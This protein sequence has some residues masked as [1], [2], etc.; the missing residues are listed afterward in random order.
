MK[1]ITAGALR[2]LWHAARAV[3]LCAPAFYQPGLAQVAPSILQIDI[4]DHVLYFEDV[5]DPA[6]F[7][8]D[9]NIPARV[10]TLGFTRTSSIADIVAVNGQRA[11]GNFSTVYCGLFLRTAPTPGLAIADII[12]NAVGVVTFEILKSDGTSI[13]TIVGTGLAGGTS[14][15]GA[16]LSATGGSN[17]AITGGTGAFLGARG[18][19]GVATNPPGVAVQRTA[20]MTED[21]ANRRRHGG[22]SQRWIA[23][24]IPMSAPQI[25]TSVSGPTVFH[26][27]FSPVTAARPAR[28]GEVLI[29]Q[30]T[31]L[32]PTVPGLDPGQP[33]PADAILQVNSPVAVTVNGQDAAVIN[34]VGWPGLVNT[35]RVDFRVPE[36]ITAGT[37]SVQ[38]SAAW[39]SGASV[40]IPVQ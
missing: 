5:A 24:V 6:R 16:P 4:A 32:G 27:D 37:A 34:A 8:T 14:P 30:A 23:H 31:G 25:L 40:S 33:F 9:S 12:R 22:G 39:V 11:M 15:P 2:R 7:G 36:G 19:I 28:P 21:P 13:G 20:S 17:F 35:Y 3:V 38:L 10:P 1:H 29:A 26:A 18:Q